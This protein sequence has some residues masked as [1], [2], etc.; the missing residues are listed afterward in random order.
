M[1][2]LLCGLAAAAP[3]GPLDAERLL[4][5]VRLLAPDLPAPPASSWEQ[6]PPADS[7]GL[8]ERIAASAAR[9]K[10]LPAQARQGLWD[11]AFRHPVAGLDDERKL[12][13]YDPKGFIGFCF[14]RA[15]AVHL[16]ARQ[17]GLAEGS[18][19]KLFAVGD[20]RE[21][22]D[23][24]WRFHVTALV[25]GEG[26]QWYAIDPVMAGPM[27]A[28]AWLAELRKTWDKQG[29]ARFYL[30]PAAAVLPELATVPA[31][32]QE[33]GEHLIEL[34][35][36]PAV[37]EG[38]FP[39]AGLGQGVFSVSRTA[40][41]KHFKAAGRG[42]DFDGIAVNGERISYNGFFPDLLRELAFPAPRSMA[43][44]FARPAPAA[45]PLGLDL[46]RLGRGAK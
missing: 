3:V 30:T 34:S 26:G 5:E 18:V 14:G 44:F 9:L 43:P 1:A 16:L 2:G 15:M 22:N 35:F 38:F 25:K 10:S 8:Y 20:L 17:L 24:G 7:G 46:G 29:Q 31:P 23:P 39:A 42:F 11:S 41:E 28:A 21:G 12:A 4:E 36:D 33:R 13:R 6:V 19:R 27:T 32:G 37:Q 40:A 45:R